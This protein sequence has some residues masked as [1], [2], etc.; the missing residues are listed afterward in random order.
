MKYNHKNIVFTVSAM[1]LFASCGNL[2]NEV[3]NKIN[4]LKNKTEYLDS[5]INTEVDKVLSL[6]TLIDRESE[7]VKKLDTLINKSSSQLDS[8]FKKGSKLL[9][10]I[11]N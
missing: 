7:K 10:K 6:D 9:E 8:I 4:E 2:S 3:E 5:L 1:L 11:T